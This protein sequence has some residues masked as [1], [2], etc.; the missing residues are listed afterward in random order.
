MHH[1]VS[2][3]AGLI[4]GLVLVAA[5]VGTGT[6]LGTGAPG[7]ADLPPAPGTGVAEVLDDAG[8]QLGPATKFVRDDDGTIRQLR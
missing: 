1:V 5:T 3:R 8:V 7:P 4:A 6:A 2:T